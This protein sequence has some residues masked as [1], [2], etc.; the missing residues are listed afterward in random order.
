MR[1]KFKIFCM[2]L[3]SFMLTFT[4][5]CS[6]DSVK[7]NHGENEEKTRTV[8]CESIDYNDHYERL[9]ES[10][11][12]V[13]L[14]FDE[15]YEQF[16]LKA[17][18]TIPAD[19]FA[20]IDELS[21]TEEAVSDV[22]VTYE[23]S[24]DPESNLVT[25][26]AYSNGEIGDILV[27]C[28]F[29]DEEGNVDV[30]FSVDEEIILLSELEE[31]G[32]IQNCGWFKK[33][34]KKITKVAT[35]VAVAAVAVV[36]VAAVAY[37]AAPVIASVVTTV[38]SCGTGSL[39]AAGVGAIAGGV[40][41]S[42][43]AAGAATVAST[44]LAVAAVSATVAAAGVIEQEY[45]IIESALTA[46]NKGVKALAIAVVA[47]IAEITLDRVYYFAHLTG[48]L[49]INYNY[50]MN[51]LEAY[52]VLLESGLINAGSSLGKFTVDML[53][54]IEI[55]ATLRKLIDWIK[56]NKEIKKGYFG[57]YTQTEENAAKLAYVAGG[58]FK[59]L[60][61]SENHDIRKG[62]GY[63]Y[64]FHDFSH[65]IHVWYGSAA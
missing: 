45:Q 9:L 18:Q 57:I 59:G 27:G 22:K 29:T 25:L 39:A 52:V 31:T 23:T 49:N 15:E 1:T 40:S 64:H 21:A 11:D 63:Y 56:N 58:F 3:A 50:S 38:V 62:S 19:V 6:L 17:T 24:Y 2:L 14:S 12:E 42:S 43:I 10:C 53:S 36:A 4:C 35:V 5:L 16:N 55:S 13:E 32:K 26:I 60:P 30:A 54:K 48:V 51:Y 20:E 44:A 37:V 34:V 8:E 47:T 41:A 46:V 7:F 33:L 61:E 28:P 65:S